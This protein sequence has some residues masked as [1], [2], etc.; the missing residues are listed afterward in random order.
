[1]EVFL[2]A[3]PSA[4]V[5]MILIVTSMSGNS[6]DEGLGLLLFGPLDETFGGNVQLALFL[7]SCASSIFSSAFGVTR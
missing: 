7:L 1:M 4:F 5:F 2:E 3:T 6:E